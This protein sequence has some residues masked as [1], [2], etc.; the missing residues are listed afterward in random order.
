V[1]INSDGSFSCAI[2]LQPG[3][4]TI[5]IRVTDLAGNEALDM[6]TINLDQNA[7]L[8]TITT[9]ADNMNTK[10]P[11]IDVAGTVDEQSTVMIEIDAADQMAALMN[12]NN[13]SLP[14][15]LLYGI[16]TIEVTATDFAGNASAVKRTVT[17]DDQKPSLSVTYPDQDIKT[18][19]N[20]ITFR[21]EVSDL[22]VVAIT[23]TVDGNIYT[24]AVTNGR[25]EQTVIFTEGK[26]YQIYIKAV[27]E[28]GNETLV[29]RNVVYDTMAPSVMRDLE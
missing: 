2:V 7:P 28:A 1:A 16:N 25:F 21:G 18:S 22:S 5:G 14:I 6:R 12:G 23:V 26:T 11:S 17:F 15:A 13:F 10:Q 27:D 8:I 4:N 20:T 9:P 19:H 24:P 3:P 29:Q